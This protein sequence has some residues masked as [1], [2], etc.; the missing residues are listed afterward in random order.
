[1]NKYDAERF[2]ILNNI[3]TDT[4]RQRAWLRSCLNE[5]CLER[6]ITAL[7]QNESLVR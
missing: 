4:G 5:N 3:K 1:M 2:E 6:F 7:V